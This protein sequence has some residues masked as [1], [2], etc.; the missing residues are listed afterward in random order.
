MNPKHLL[1]SGTYLVA[2]ARYSREDEFKLH[3]FG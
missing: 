3:A 2:E 1:F